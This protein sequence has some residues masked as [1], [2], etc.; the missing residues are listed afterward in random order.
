MKEKMLI[1]SDALVLVWLGARIEIYNRLITALFRKRI[2]LFICP[3]L[4]RQ[5]MRLRKDFLMAEKRHLSII[6]LDI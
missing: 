3:T 1:L 4:D 2:L 6:C 5:L